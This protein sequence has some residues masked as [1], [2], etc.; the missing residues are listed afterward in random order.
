MKQM[1]L[2]SFSQLPAIELVAGLPSVDRDERRPPINVLVMC[3]TRELADQAAQ[4]AIKLVK[5]HTSIGVQLVIGG[6]R[7]A[8]EQKGMQSNP[9]QVLHIL[10]LPQF[11][12]I[13]TL[14]SL[15]LLCV[16]GFFVI[17]GILFEYFLFL[18]VQINTEP[19]ELCKACN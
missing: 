2:F 15:L 9:C 16:V 4:E 18:V 6:T 14:R 10:C 13:Q 8:I 7:L 11:D 19:N 1:F 3:P 12:S 5:Y 17:Y